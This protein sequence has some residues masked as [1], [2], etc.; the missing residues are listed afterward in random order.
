MIQLLVVIG[1]S[2]LGALLFSSYIE[3]NK[4]ME[5]HGHEVGVLSQVGAILLIVLFIRNLYSALKTKFL[6]KAVSV[7]SMIFIFKVEG[8]NC[9]SCVKKIRTALESREGVGV[10]EIELKEARLEVESLGVSIQTI[11]S[12]VESL[13]FKLVLLSK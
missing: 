10:I 7:D 11:A 4:A 6:K 3:I 13:G 5:L 12:E 8:M 2:I 1:G 9:G